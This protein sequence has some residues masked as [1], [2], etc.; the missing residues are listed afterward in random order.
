MTNYRSFRA[1]LEQ[2]SQHPINHFS[3]QS[4]PAGQ[5]YQS[6]LKPPNSPRK[7]TRITPHVQLSTHDP[8]IWRLSPYNRYAP[9]SRGERISLSLV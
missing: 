9:I 1:K 8:H 6:Q 4:R 5:L 3:K 7:P 2:E